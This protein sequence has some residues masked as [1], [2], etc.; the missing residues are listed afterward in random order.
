MKTLMDVPTLRERMTSGQRTVVLDVRWALG[1]PDGHKHYLAGH[2]PG[3]V[4]VDLETGLAAPPAQGLGRHPLP[5]PAAFEEAAREWGINTY[6][7]VVAYDDVGGVSAAR[8]WWLLRDGGFDDVFLLDGGLAA[9]RQAGFEL[10]TGEEC[11]S[12]GD[13][14]LEPGH[15]PLLRLDEME[16]FPGTGVLL[17]ARA[18]ERYRGEKE[19]VDP[20]AG[21]IPGALSAPTT[22]NLGTGARFLPAAELRA[23]FRSLGVAHGKPIA[24]YCGSG[25]SAAH[26]I[27]ALAHAGLEAALFPGSWSQWSQLDLP[28]AVGPELRGSTPARRPA[29][30]R[31]QDTRQCQSGG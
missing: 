7:T 14:R 25:I 18:G 28:V 17:D 5:E 19:P 27:A 13:V 20:K 22:E 6:D 30:A 10:E 3:A 16:A 29:S 15:M 26:E 2:I 8:L 31:G 21:H 1:D 11:P 9:W 12:L 4:F 24:V 23:R